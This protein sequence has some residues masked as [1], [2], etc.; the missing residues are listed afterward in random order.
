MIGAGNRHQRGLLA[1]GLRHGGRQRFYLLLRAE[2]V[3]FSLHKQLRLGAR[4]EVSKVGG[5]C[6]QA[7][8]NQLR[9]ARIGTAHLQPDPRAEAEPGQQQRVPGELFG[10]KAERGAHIVGFPT[11]FVVGSFA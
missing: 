7:Q 11:A 2:L 6:R 4:A 10:E 1:L 3:A 5:V 8:A 9:H